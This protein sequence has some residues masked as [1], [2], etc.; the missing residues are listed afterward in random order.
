LKILFI[1][2]AWHPQVNGVVRT[3]LTTG[4]ELEKMG[5]TVGFIG[6][7]QFRTIGLPGYREIQVAVKPR[8]RLEKLI[9]EF[10]PE[11][12]HIATEGPLGW[13]GRAICGKKGYVFTT[14]YHT[15]FPEYLA[16]R[17]P[18]PL[19][20][21]YA[22]LRRFHRTSAAVMVATPT[23]SRALAARGF[24]NLRRWTRGVDTELFHP[25]AKDFIDAPRPVSICVGRVAVE[26]NI[27][28]FLSLN[29]PGTKFVVGGGPLLA[30]L[31]RRYP[32]VRFVGPRHGDELAAYFAAADVF[33]FP[34][35]TDTFGLVMLEALASG[36][37]VAA[38]PVQG[39]LDVIGDSEV[40]V[41][42]EDLGSAVLR[43]LKIAPERC[44]DFALNYSW[45]AAAQQFLSNVHPCA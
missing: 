8:R 2:D 25:R 26:K 45:T 31:K 41:L 1:T 17:L 19:S 32:E 24:A 14:S 40:G 16:E 29:I 13:A 28:A 43:A 27:E 44:R 34:S 9:M 23:V 20:V 35:R 4:R 39:P 38:Y 12:I 30:T 21:S 36:V 5:H 18:V 3:L 6:P 37:P 42:D 15:S 7:D 10:G 11:A 22:V 33:V